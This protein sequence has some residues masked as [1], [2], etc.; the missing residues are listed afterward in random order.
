[1]K[2]CDLKADKAALSA[3]ERRLRGCLGNLIEVHE[4]A[5]RGDLVEPQFGSYF[6]LA[7]K[8]WEV[9]EGDERRVLYA[10]TGCEAV[11]PPH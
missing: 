1:M 2:P 5:K 11:D 7:V 10:L 3:I 8:S 6:D 9:R 4:A